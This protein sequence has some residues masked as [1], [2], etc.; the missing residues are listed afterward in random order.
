MTGGKKCYIPHTHRL[1]ESDEQKWEKILFVS[2]KNKE[3]GQ[4]EAH[5]VEQEKKRW[6]FLISITRL[7]ILAGQESQ[8]WSD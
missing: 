4:T 7:S 3:Q 2:E 1:L 5:Q 8:A 6:T